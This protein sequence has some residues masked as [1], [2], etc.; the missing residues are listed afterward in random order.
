METN[1]T[2]LNHAKIS[3][4]SAATLFV[5]AVLFN[6]CSSD[7]TTEKI[8]DPENERY[9]VALQDKLENL[10]AISAVDASVRPENNAKAKLG[11]FLYFDTRLSK[12]GKNS[13]N[14]CHNLNTFGVDNLPFSPGDKGLLGGRNSP[15]TLN[16]ALHAS[17]FWDGRAKDVEEQ[18]G[19][20]ILNPIEMNIPSEQFLIDRL[21]TIDLY[22][23]LFATAY[24]TE[25]DP[26]TYKNVQDAIGAFER[27]LITPSRYDE[28]LNGKKDA[29]TLD[30]KKGLMSFTQV[31]C[32]NCH[33]GEALGG[34]AGFQKF[35]M[36]ANYW[37]Y[38]KST[39]RDEGR[40][41]LT[42]N[43]ADKYFFKVP[44]LRNIEKTHPYFHDG[45][46]KSLDEA[47]KIM[48]KTQLN[49]KL[50]NEEVKNITAFLKA[51]NG[52]IPADY[53]TAPMGL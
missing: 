47:V 29:L 16:A 21:K 41:E 3:F 39:K 20:P 23:K 17:Q 51:L 36:F 14:S 35:G 49:Y 30:E 27:A 40:F 1:S 34:G 53:K 43:E 15:T 10:K 6:A 11:Q 38:T 18:A 24:P 7:K 5:L 22:K 42:K 26:F 44:S 50:N 13:C 2:I 9:D 33:N 4:V 31:G 48:A 12:D 46:V 25:Q 8:V 19:G 37:D 45:S 32:I 52:D 28:Y